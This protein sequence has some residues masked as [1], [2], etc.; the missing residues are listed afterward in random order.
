MVCIRGKI[1]VK[2]VSNFRIYFKWF[3][4]IGGFYFEECKVFNEMNVMIYFKG[5]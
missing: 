3:F 4:V 1:L 2:D 5:L